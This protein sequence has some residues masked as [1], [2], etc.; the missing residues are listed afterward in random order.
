LEGLKRWADPVEILS[1]VVD[2]AKGV[3]SGQAIASSTSSPSLNF[4][5][6]EPGRSASTSEISLNPCSFLQPFSASLQSCHPARLVTLNRTGI[7][8][9]RNL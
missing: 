8:G 9:D 4:F 1:I 7:I 3:F 2:E 5:P 6:V